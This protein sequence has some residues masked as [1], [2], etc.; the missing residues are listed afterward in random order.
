MIELICWI[1]WNYSKYGS[2]E[3]TG[4]DNVRKSRKH[5]YK[6]LIDSKQKLKQLKYLIW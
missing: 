5:I 2:T 1:D 3:L 4:R 6:D